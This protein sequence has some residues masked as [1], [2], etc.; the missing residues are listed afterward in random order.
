MVWAA[1]VRGLLFW[2]RRSGRFR[3]DRGSRA[4]RFFPIATIPNLR[5]PVGD[6][7]L[8]SAKTLID[9]A[10]PEAALFIKKLA[11]KIIH[12]GLERCSLGHY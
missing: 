8:F 1:Q 11:L 4:P 12:P 3:S 9:E 6:F 5:L 10:T 7:L 2:P